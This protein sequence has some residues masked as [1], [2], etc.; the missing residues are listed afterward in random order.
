MAT[1]YTKTNLI[2]DL[3]DLNKEMREAG[4]VYSFSY[5]S[6]NNYH[7]VDLIRDGKIVRNIDSARTPREL[8]ER[9]QDEAEYYKKLDV[10]A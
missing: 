8:F 3:E 4:S 6:R 9:A 7:A 1:R 5:L 10:A 2:A